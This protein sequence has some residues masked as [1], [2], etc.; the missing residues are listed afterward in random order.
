MSSQMTAA[1]SG[2]GAGGLG[3]QVGHAAVAGDPGGGE[4]PVGLALGAGLQVQAAG[5]DVPVPG[6]D[7]PARRQPGLGGRGPG[8]A[9][10]R[11]GPAVPGWRSGRRT[12]PGPARPARPG[13][14]RRLR[15]VIGVVVLALPLQY[16]HDCLACRA[17][18]SLRAFPGGDADL[19]PDLDPVRPFPLR[20][21]IADHPDIIAYSRRIP[22]TDFPGFPPAVAAAHFLLLFLR[23]FPWLYLRGRALARRGGC[24]SIPSP[25]AAP[26]RACRTAEVKVELPT[27]RTTLT[28]AGRYAT[29]PGPAGTGWTGPRTPASYGGEP[30]AGLGPSWSPRPRRRHQV[31]PG[32]LFLRTGRAGGARSSRADSTNTPDQHRDVGRQRRRCRG[33]AAARPG[34]A[35]R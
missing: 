35:R 27:G 31:F 17:S 24:L 1:N 14:P 3:E 18:I 16:L 10:R 25:S 33:T 32:G 28:G 30:G 15:R 29:F 8:G 22:R 6:G 5:F 11:P 2:H 13:P 9:A 20:Y 34:T 4:P 26:W 19:E 21:I 7:E 12:R 23:A